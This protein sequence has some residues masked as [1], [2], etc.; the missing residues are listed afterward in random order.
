MPFFFCL[1]LF[2]VLL[3][4]AS[5][6]V[7]WLLPLELGKSVGWVDESPC[8]DDAARLEA[9]SLVAASC[10]RGGGGVGA[11]CACGGGTNWRNCCLV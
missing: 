1:S 6:E 5:V 2:L 7:D 4:R 3:V 11:G 9:A 10:P 8:N